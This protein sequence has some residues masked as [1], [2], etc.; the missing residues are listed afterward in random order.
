LTLEFLSQVIEP[1]R[2]V[3]S[4]EP[5]ADW[6]I[7]T[8]ATVSISEDQ[9]FHWNDGN[10]LHIG[11]VA[12]NPPSFAVRFWDLAQATVQFD[13]KRIELIPFQDGIPPETLEH[14]LVD[15]VFPRIIA[16]HGPLVLHAGGVVV[17]ERAVALLGPSGS[18]KSTLS[19][20]L[21]QQGA[22]LLCDDALVV[23]SNGGSHVAHGTYPGLRL[24]PDS[25]EGLSLDTGNTAPF[26]HYSE[27]LRVNYQAKGGPG[28]SPWPLAALVFLAQTAS[29]SPI[30]LR[31]LPLAQACIG[32]ITN[33]F[34]L[35]PTDM[36]H[37][38]AKLAL[39]S[40]LAADVP[41]FE[42]VYPHGFDRLAEVR[43][44]LIEQVISCGDPYERPAG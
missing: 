34:S 15:Q 26:A 33:S 32:L 41:A 9:S 11:K 37:L 20:Y 5:C 40:A 42:L 21:Q 25:F 28:E 31:P 6:S 38:Q 14:L 39:A 12:G 29:E 16:H 24:F 2:H 10:G 30:S 19:A 4:S 8:A 36:D 18:G 7:S 27:K 17:A 43:A 23:S 13:A 22:I 44:M 35:D 1:H 3:I